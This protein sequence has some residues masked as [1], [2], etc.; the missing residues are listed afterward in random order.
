[1]AMARFTLPAAIL[2]TLLFEMALAERKYALFGG[3]FGA[4]QVL[5]TPGE[6]AAFA[7]GVVAC[8]ALLLLLLYRLIRRLHG[9]KADGP[10]FHFNFLVLAGG[11]MIGAAAGKYQAL[12]YFSDAMSFQI[13]RNL[14]GGSLTDALLFSLNEIGL[15]AIGLGGAAICYLGILWLLR[16]R[17][18]NAAP[19]A[20]HWRPSRR[21]WAAM[22][23]ATPMILFGVN[24]IDD[25]RSAVGRFNSALAFGSVLHE[26]T[27]FD[28]DGW[29]L[30]SF[31]VDRAPFDGAL[32]PYALDVPGD[33]IDQD[34]FGGD[35]TFA[36]NSE[37]GPP[38]AIPAERR[39]HVV[40]IVLES[41]RGDAIGMRIDGRP[42]APNIEAMA[43]SGSS[44]RA[45]YSHVGFTTQSLQSLFSG[46]LAPHD[47]RQS[48]IRDFLANGYRV[49]VLS[50]QAEDF[51][52]TANL[53][54]MRLGEF[55]VDA[56]T[57]REERAFSFAAQGSLAID[58]RVQLREF[59][60][61]LG[62]PEQWRRPTFLY[63]NLQ[64]AHFPYS[65][66]GMPRAFGGEPIP[67]GEISPANR[68]WLIRT[69]WNAIAYNDALIG[70]I[71]ERLRRLGVLDDTL[72]VVTADH[73]ES[74]FDDGFLGHGH[75]LNEQQ[76]RI[77]FVLSDAGVTMPPAIGL[78][79]M[80]GIVL[81]ALGADAPGRNA[82]VFQYLGTLDRP[83]MIGWVGAD[84]RRL[85]FNLNSEAVWTTG[86][87]RWTRHA[88][89]HPASAERR[90]ADGLIREWARQRWLRHLA[91]G[92]PRSS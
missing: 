45:A 84:G 33:G 5:D 25:A 61:R 72:I 31:P 80:R 50:G 7:V 74:L 88:D 68:D 9:G 51:G 55:F 75:A 13:V 22:L 48:L 85:I 44:A 54:G 81:R 76:T 27:D 12:A 2:V 92:D 57:N 83:G 3:G 17:W 87:G 42:V 79:D 18:R 29:S 32:H 49:G 39:R 82:P 36:G 19:L 70:A 52:D 40:L 58:G 64:S 8:Q 4:S 21:Q 73:G 37:A 23:V 38:A 24:R 15:A 43:R 30:F 28:R 16:R 1:R 62:R 46:Q 34:G 66:P 20:D 65:W 47:S 69:Y 90:A 63:I 67:R 35:F 53:T 91:G 6:I 10:L 14:G 26:A 77:P 60:R 86:R 41:T 56:T 11:G 71:R 89:L 59:D 78:S